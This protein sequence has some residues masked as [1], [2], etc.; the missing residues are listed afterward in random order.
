MKYIIWLKN[1]ITANTKKAMIRGIKKG[2]GLQDIGIDFIVKNVELN[3]Y[4][5]N[6]QRPDV[7]ILIHTG[8]SG[9][10]LE[11][12]DEC[13]RVQE[14][15]HV[16]G[17]QAVSTSLK[18][19]PNFYYLRDWDADL[20]NEYLAGRFIDLVKEN[21]FEIGKNA[22]VY[23]LNNRFAPDITNFNSILK[24]RLLGDNLTLTDDIIPEARERP[25]ELFSTTNFSN[26]EKEKRKREAVMPPSNRA[27]FFTAIPIN[28]NSLEDMLLKRT[29]DNTIQ[30]LNNKGVI[31][32]YITP[33]MTRL[34]GLPIPELQETRAALLNSDA[35][36]ENLFETAGKTIHY[37]QLIADWTFTVGDVF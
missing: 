20:E 6:L 31:W 11:T 33:A 9:E 19:K 4:L 18:T 35:R 21:N 27:L 13:P 2:T 14:L 37:W 24:D 25:E 29:G 23:T 5:E 36:Y 34:V 7:A 1:K 3:K 17:L 28:R 30:I 12:Y 16:Q 26:S 15:M 22:E 10:L 32:A 8:T